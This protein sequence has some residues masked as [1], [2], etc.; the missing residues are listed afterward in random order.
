MLELSVAVEALGTVGTGMAA[1]GS[2]IV[3]TAAR[4]RAAARIKFAS[5]FMHLLLI[6][7]GDEKILQSQP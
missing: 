3:K 7:V 6:S 4:D 2:S 5:R 1:A